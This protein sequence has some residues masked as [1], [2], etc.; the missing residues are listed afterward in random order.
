MQTVLCHN[1]KAA[2][3][4]GVEC[5]ERVKLVVGVGEEAD[6]E[7]GWGH[8]HLLAGQAEE[9]PEEHVVAAADLH[10][11]P[12]PVFVHKVVKVSCNHRT[13]GV[14]RETDFLVEDGIL[15]EA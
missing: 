2:P 1:H 8:V 3:V 12:A 6:G 11:K 10:T 14:V 4:D 9:H 7:F 5:A 13:I 15:G